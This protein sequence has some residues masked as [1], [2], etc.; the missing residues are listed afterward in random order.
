M[1]YA[2]LNTILPL[3]FGDSSPAPYSTQ[4]IKKLVSVTVLKQ[5]KGVLKGEKQLTVKGAVGFACS[6]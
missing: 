3:F 4:I 5:I 1:E 2:D 6:L